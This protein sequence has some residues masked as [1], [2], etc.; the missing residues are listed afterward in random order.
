MQCGEVRMWSSIRY[1]VFIA[2]G[3]HT[4]DMMERSDRV[5]HCIRIF[6]VSLLHV[7]LSGLPLVGI[8]DSGILIINVKYHITKYRVSGGS[9]AV[10]FDF[11]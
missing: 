11:A 4:S 8:E 9:S 1:L 3:L 2:T 10:G 7:C 6:P 5:R